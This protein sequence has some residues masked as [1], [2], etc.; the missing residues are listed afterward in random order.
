MCQTDSLM[1]RIICNVEPSVCCYNDVPAL[2][3]APAPPAPYSARSHREGCVGSDWS[4]VDC[5]PPSAPPDER[6]AACE[7][8]APPA[9]PAGSAA[10]G[11][12]TRESHTHTKH[13]W[14]KHESL[15]GTKN[16]LVG[17]GC[18]VDLIHPREINE[19]NATLSLYIIWNVCT[20][21]CHCVNTRICHL[22]FIHSTTGS[23]W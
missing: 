16:N 14:G 3:P 21:S 2:S 18:L 12:N 8:R 22:W 20:Y 15:P 9:A 1:S 6:S 7:T 23:V 19:L 10:A 13:T 17:E 11:T 5:V 4:P